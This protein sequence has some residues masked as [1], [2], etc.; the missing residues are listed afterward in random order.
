MNKL[1]M[2]LMSFILMFTMSCDEDDTIVGGGIDTEPELVGCEATTF[3]DWSDFEFS[4]SLDAGATTWFF[5][6][7]IFQTGT[8]QRLSCGRR[9]G[10]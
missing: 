1:M 10:G 6:S 9:S 8:G 7:S 3:Y 2:F 5:S 4:T